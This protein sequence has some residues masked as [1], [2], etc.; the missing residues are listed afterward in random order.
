MADSPETYLPLALTEVIIDTLESYNSVDPDRRMAL[1]M[2]L[3][4]YQSGTFRWR[5]PLVLKDSVDPPTALA[6]VATA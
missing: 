4:F 5:S 2:A 1:E 6:D 3:L